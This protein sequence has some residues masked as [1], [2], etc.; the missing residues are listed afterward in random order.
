VFGR[1]DGDWNDE[2]NY[3]TYLFTDRNFGNNRARCLRREFEGDPGAAKIAAAQ[4][5]SDND[6]DAVYIFEL[7]EQGQYVPDENG[8]EEFFWLEDMV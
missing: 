5:C 8:L 6:M 4:F 7:V 2:E 1:Y 3:R